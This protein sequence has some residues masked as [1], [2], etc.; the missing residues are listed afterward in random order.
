M[1]KL[2]SLSD[3]YQF[4]LD[5]E[6]PIY[7]VSG[8]PFNVLGLGQQVPSLRYIS[9][10]DCFDGHHYRVFS[11]NSN[12]NPEFTCMEDVVNYLLENKDVE[13]FVDRTGNGLM[14]TVMFDEE[15][16]KLAKALGLK[17]ALPPA[18]LRTHIDSKIV[19]TRLG[20]EANVP[21][22]PNT[23]G[24]ADT[25][26]ELNALSEGAGIGTDLV[27]Q[28]PY[29]DSGRTTFFIKSEEDWDK[30]S[31][32]IIG[33]QL[34]VMKRID[35]ISGTVEGVATR[36]GTLVGPIMME[37]VGHSKL[38]PY[39]GGWSGNENDPNFFE[40]ERR[41]EIINM[42]QRLG[43]RLYKEGYRGTFCMDFLIDT[44][45]G[46]SYLGEINPRISGA[47]PMTNLVTQKYGGVPMLFFHL[48][49]Y[50]DVDWELDLS[51]IQSRWMDYGCWSTLVIK[52]TDDK[53]EIITDAP[54]SGIYRYDEG[55][56][57]FLR[58]SWDWSNV[59]SYKQGFYLRVLGAGEYV[60]KGADLGILLLRGRAQNDDGS[61]TSRVKGWIAA[62]RD[63]YKTTPPAGDAQVPEPKQKGLLY[64]IN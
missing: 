48:L 4:F 34:K 19:T 49:E 7:F 58:R 5:L 14:L 9:Y 35:N 61:L 56:I 54:S 25:Y 57:N 8:T 1:K 60:Y 3:I 32:N 30:H 59:S 36:N 21:S 50:L 39:K 43:D 38:T 33:E 42:V 55:D 16:E 29:G 31:E 12:D 45:T 40:Q 26:E 10:F 24:T 23:M 37:V 63:Q 15:T 28:T 51:T 64:K 20:D 22:V 53:V 11:P 17:I 52:N 18:S 44:A 41:D 2:R 6:E 13:G 62:I 27:V 46:E 47:S